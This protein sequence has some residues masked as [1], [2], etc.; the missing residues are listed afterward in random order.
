[1][2]KSIMSVVLIAMLGIVSLSGCGSK[3]VEESSREIKGEITISCYDAMTYKIFLEQAAQKFEEKYPG[4]TVTVETAGNMPEIKTQETDGRRMALIQNTDSPQEREDYISRI[5]TELMSGQG[6]DIIALDG[7][8]PF[9]KYADSRQL[10]D[11]TD[12]MNN[13]SSFVKSDYA[14][15]IFDGVK[16]KGVQYIFPLDYTFDYFSYDSSL[17]PD[18]PAR[19][20]MT[21]A[22]VFDAA[23]DKAKASNHKVFG[24]SSYSVQRD[25]SLFSALFNLD[26]EKYV[27]VADKK[28][29]LTNGDFAR[30]LES[31]QSYADEGL[32]NQ[33]ALTDVRGD[34]TIN[35]SA[36]Q[37]S[38]QEKYYAKR[39]M[40]INLLNQFTRNLNSGM[41]TA[42][43]VAGGGGDA[44]TD[45][46][47][48][49]IANDKAEVLFSYVLGFGIN[50]NSKNKYTAWEFLKF[51]A[52]EE[53]QS[54]GLTP[55]HAIPVN[56]NAREML[57]AM[58][59]TG[60]AMQ[61]RAANAGGPFGAVNTGDPQE[62]PPPVNT[63][64]NPEQQ[65]ALENYLKQLDIFTAQLNKYAVHDY[66]I[67]NMIN[68][69]V[70][71]F[72]TGDKSA[73]EVANTLQSKVN[74]Y[75]NE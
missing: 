37:E 49:L 21:Y 2:V 56:K 29:D 52:D 58:Y 22:D 48:G 28:L 71:A 62:M 57:A 11:L 24:L 51:L 61:R 70:R 5:N 4:T 23:A 12:Y 69:E 44:S 65:Q 6:A 67:D 27:N 13:D 41:R 35:M 25:T 40:N 17:Y 53:I 68:T 66:T 8:L 3:P 42:M 47:A 20:K 38:R 34:G 50:S 32:I 19:D 31:V 36:F 43:M 14:E 74:L 72:F 18:F 15:N 45:E 59:I 9:Y 75:L 10:A 1:M 64:L 39:S 55:P 46:I 54:S 60:E 16:Y 73:D 63:E 30:L 26:Y 33:A 7:A